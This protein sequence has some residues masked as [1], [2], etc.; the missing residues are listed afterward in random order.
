MNDQPSHR[1]DK[2]YSFGLYRFLIVSTLSAIAALLGHQ[3]LPEK[4]LQLLPYYI[5]DSYVFYDGQAGGATRANWQSQQDLSFFCDAPS[6]SNNSYCG[7]S[8]KVKPPEAAKDYT[9]YRT[10]TFSLGYSGPNDR[11]RVK[12]HAYV[13]P[14]NPESANE[15]LTGLDYIVA[16]QTLDEQFT[17]PVNAWHV[18]EPDLYSGEHGAVQLDVV[19]DIVPPLQT[20]QHA[21]QVSQITLRGDW[22]PVSYWYGVVGVVW[23]VFNIVFLGKL[24]K[25]QQARIMNDANRLSQLTH[26]SSHLKEESEHYKTLSS[27]DPLTGALNRSGFAQ[28]FRHLF[29][30]NRL[31]MNSALLVIDLDHFKQVNDTHG[32]DV[33]DKVLQCCAETLFK[34]VRLND[35]LVRWGGEEFILLCVD[36]SLQQAQLIAEKIRAMIEEMKIDAEQQSLSVTAS[37]GVAVSHHLEDFD[38]LFQ[39]ADKALYSAKELG[40]NCVVLADNT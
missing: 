13:P 4:T 32:H 18:S 26:F 23:L 11:L 12:L 14:Q 22:L 8:L 37:I 34:N 5:H 27:H 7:V 40:R 15:I 19:F 9:D 33:G 10:A 20:G 36:T 38:G 1:T 28:E 21:L 3:L 29:P 2:T 39:R 35:R 16:K 24:L 25:V 17:I 6:V 31:K 30:D